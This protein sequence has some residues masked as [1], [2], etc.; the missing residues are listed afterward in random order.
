[1]LMNALVGCRTPPSPDI[2]GRC[3][4]I[5]SGVNPFDDRNLPGDLAAWQGDLL[6]GLAENVADCVVIVVE[7]GRLVDTRSQAAKRLP[8]SRND[9]RR[10]P[11]RA[12]PIIRESSPWKGG[13][14]ENAG[15]AILGSS[16]MAGRVVP[17]PNHS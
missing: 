5:F 12:A 7:P 10:L 8:G 15:Y 4:H 6:L 1:M 17:S 9:G 11:L 14:D 3:H 16:V 13:P 2:P